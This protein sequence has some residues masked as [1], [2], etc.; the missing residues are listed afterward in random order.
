MKRITAVYHYHGDM[1]GTTDVLTCDLHHRGSASLPT[2]WASS[3]APSSYSSNMLSVCLCSSVILSFCVLTDEYKRAVGFD[4]TERNNWSYSWGLNLK[5][6]TASP[7]SLANAAS[8]ST[9]LSSA[10]GA[11]NGGARRLLDIVGY[12]TSS[13]TQHRPLLNIVGY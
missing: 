3:P 2:I 7:L 5:F 6:P 12:S 4:H 1:W 13:V 9:K 8:V 11:G 10:V